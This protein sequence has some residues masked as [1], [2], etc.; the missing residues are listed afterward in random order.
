MIVTEREALEFIKEGH[1]HFFTQITI[2][3][4]I[5]GYHEQQLKVLIGKW[6]GLNGWAFPGGHIG[7]KETLTSA[8]NRI[9]KDRTSIDQIFLEQFHTFGDSQ[10]R[11]QD[12]SFLQSEIND[13][14]AED[15]WL[16]QRTFSVG[17]YAL[18]E[19]S[20]VKIKTDFFFEEFKWI[21]ISEIPTLLFDHNE[22]LEVALSTLR[23]QIYHKPIGF[24]L[25]PD[26]FTLPEI[27]SLYETILGKTLDRRNF[28]KKLLTLNL[29]TKLEE[30]KS[31]GKHRSPFLYKFDTEKYNNA[32]KEGI[33]LV[34]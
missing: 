9:L 33:I 12:F 24:N 34:F 15:S 7:R 20:E 1:K 27:I 18:I 16:F 5:F 23:K 14:V 13:Q 30:K 10:Y 19:Y 4:V 2:D 6:K 21:D 25:L 26:K 31:I 11:L 17:F 8:A 32:L 22:V 3:C 28:P 29:I